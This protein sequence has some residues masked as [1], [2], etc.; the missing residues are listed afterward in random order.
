MAHNTT[1]DKTFYGTSSRNYGHH[2]S[3]LPTE[4]DFYLILTGF[5]KLVLIYTTY[6]NCNNYLALITTI[7]ISP[8]MI[9]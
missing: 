8:F 6:L 9:T 4:Q 5:N 3:L 1:D 7:T 2:Y